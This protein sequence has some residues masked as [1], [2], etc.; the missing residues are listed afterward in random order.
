MAL[1]QYRKAAYAATLI[2][3]EEQNAGEVTCAQKLMGNLLRLLCE[4]KW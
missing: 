1:K 3:Q 2:A 4:T